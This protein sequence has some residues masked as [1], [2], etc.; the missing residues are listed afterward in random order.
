MGLLFSQSKTA[1]TFGMARAYAIIQLCLV[2]LFSF[3][4]NT[5]ASAKDQCDSIKLTA[6]PNDAP[7]SWVNSDGKL[8]G[9]SI[10]LAE[11]LLTQMGVNQ[12]ETVAFPTVG[13]A[14]QAT[15]RGDVDM[16]T[17]LGMAVD[18]NSQFNYIQPAYYRKLV[19]VVVRK[20]EGFRLLSYDDLKKRRGTS[21]A[22]ITFGQ[23]EFGKLVGVEI[24]TEKSIDIKDSFDKLLSGDVYFNLL[25][26]RT[27]EAWIIR[28]NLWDKVDILPVLAGSNDYYMAWSRLSKCRNQKFLS[29]FSEALSN[30][31]NVE[32]FAE[33][34]SQYESQYVEELLFERTNSLRT[35]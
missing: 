16:I 11:Q 32:A 14:V 1:G 6:H 2:I 20:N 21:G 7:A 9:A 27:A 34:L 10:A 15:L 25:Y 5:A 3:G 22:S 8:V 19:V 31:N 26:R 28:N 29:E 17:A 23:G 33:L 4:I 30:S 35:D 18:R 12:F 24:A 13:Q